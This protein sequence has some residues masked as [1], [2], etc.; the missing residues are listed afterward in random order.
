MI[1]KWRIIFI[2]YIKLFF[3]YVNPKRITH[4]SNTKGGHIHHVLNTPL[5]KFLWKILIFPWRLTFNFQDLL[6]SE[7][8]VFRHK[9]K[10]ALHC[11]IKSCW[12]PAPRDKDSPNTGSISHM[13]QSNS[14]DCLGNSMFS[15]TII[16][17]RGVAGAVLQT[18]DSMWKH[19]EQHDLF[20]D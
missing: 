2:N 5:R 15:F 4:S 13:T 17:R 8:R 7:W 10:D 11:A 18:G 14:K 19:R 3:F 12:L 6:Y 20:F 9:K 16:N 1:E